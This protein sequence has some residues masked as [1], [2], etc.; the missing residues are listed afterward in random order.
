MNASK[1]LND[2]L[3]S[4]ARQAEPGDRLPTVRSLMAQFGVS[5]SVVQRI[6]ERLKAEG[7][8]SAE[9]GRGTFFVG[10]PGS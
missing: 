3:E 5:Q 9:T 10:D 1:R 7:R 6:T 2:Y 8:I 4:L